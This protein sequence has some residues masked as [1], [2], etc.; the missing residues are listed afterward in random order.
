M[1]KLWASALTYVVLSNVMLYKRT[2]NKVP[3]MWQDGRRRTGYWEIRRSLMYQ[4]YCRNKGCYE[5][6]YRDYIYKVQKRKRNS[7]NNY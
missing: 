2:P 6:G 3:C 1:D 7:I 5:C 4:N